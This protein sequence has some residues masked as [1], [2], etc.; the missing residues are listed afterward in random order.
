M[1]WAT[2]ISSIGFEMAVPP[3][4]GYWLDERWGTAPW[5]VLTGACLGFAVAMLDVRKLA[6]QPARLGQLPEGPPSTKHNG[7]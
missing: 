4:I 6:K 3:A 5:L 2:R 7:R 1:Y